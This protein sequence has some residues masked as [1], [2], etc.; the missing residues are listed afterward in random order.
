MLEEIGDVA[1]KDLVLSLDEQIEAHVT[2]RSGR[3]V[4]HTG[5]GVLASFASA[6]DALGCATALQRTVTD[7]AGDPVPIQI[8]IGLAAG[9]P[10]REGDRLFGAAVNLAA[11]MCA[12]AEPSTVFVPS[13]VRELTLGKGF[14]FL[15]RGRVD[16]KGFTEPVQVFEVPWA[17]NGSG[18]DAG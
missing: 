18:T 14:T 16:L 4:D 5:D 1:A 11:R 12:V 15:D 9:E 2:E 17:P 6:A 7:R 3:R 10:I 13:A 8:R